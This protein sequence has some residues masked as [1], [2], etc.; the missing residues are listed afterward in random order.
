MK[1]CESELAFGADDNNLTNQNEN[2]IEF[3]NNSGENRKST[4]AL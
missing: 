1:L 3:E 2:P 4:G